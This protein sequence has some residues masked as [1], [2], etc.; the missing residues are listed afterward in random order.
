MRSDRETDHFF[1]MAMDSFGIVG[2]DGC[3]REV[4]PAFCEAF[5]HSREELRSK[6]LLDFVH[7]KDRERT[8]EE[9]RQVLPGDRV[10]KFENRF[11]C[12]DGLYKWMEWHTRVV[13]NETYIVLRDITAVKHFFQKKTV[14]TLYQAILDSTNYMIFSTDESGRIKVFNRT[15]ERKLGAS[16]QD[17]IDKEFW[18]LFHDPDEILMRAQMLSEELG[19]V[20]E[21]GLEVFTVRALLGM[22][23]EHEW[24]L[25]RQDGVSF[26]VRLSV[27]ALRDDLGGISGFLG[28][29]Q[30]ITSHMQAREEIRRFAAIVESSND[31]IIA[32][33]L[34]GEIQ[35]WNAAAE[36]LFGYTEEEMLGQSSMVLVPEDLREEL[37]NLYNR[38]SVGLHVEPFETVRICHDGSKVEVALTLSLIYGDK[39]EALGVSSIAYDI[40]TR[41]LNE[42]LLQDS[43][44]RMRT[45]VETVV[46][47]IVSINSEGII[48]RFNPAAQRMFGYSEKEIIGKNVKILMPYHIA[49]EHDKYL[50]RYMDHSNSKVVGAGHEVEENEKTIRFFRWN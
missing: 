26:P 36:R 4:N 25:I 32:E 10:V 11:R 29:A 46:D 3:L 28:V 21:P 18:T 33:S 44:K 6:P 43:E 9:I 5:G 40:T 42:R 20:V 16:I 49:E 8:S 35:I 48:E 7:P 14:E 31:A 24:T 50:A 41:K 30:D 37:S 17:V 22:P 27:T 23:D 12:Q 45:F 39:G 19:V 1:Q 47:G 2:E 13:E 34:D 38:L 15:S